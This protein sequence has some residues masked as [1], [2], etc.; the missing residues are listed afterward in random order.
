MS[1]LNNICGQICQKGSSK[2]IQLEDHNLVIKRQMKLKAICLCSC[3][4]LIKFQVSSVNLKSWIIQV[5]KLKFSLHKFSH[6]CD[7]ICKKRGLTAFTNSW[8]WLIITSNG[9]DLP[10]SNFSPVNSTML[11]VYSNW[12]SGWYLNHNG[13][14]GLPSTCNWK[15][16]RPIFADLVKYYEQTTVL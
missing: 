4:Q 9:F 15:A 8:V 13:N 10:S 14:Y 12:I 7:R 5:D 1:Y 16:I 3:F 11:M 6:I 2:H